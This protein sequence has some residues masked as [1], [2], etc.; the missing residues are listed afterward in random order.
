MNNIFITVTFRP[1]GSIAAFGNV[2]NN[3]LK[4]TLSMQKDKQGAFSSLKAG[5][6]APVC[7]YLVSVN[8]GRDP[9]FRPRRAPK[10]S[11]AA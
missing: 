3:I 4:I 9:F 6:N 5:G 8:S 2:Y 10:H 11:A 1:G 7:V